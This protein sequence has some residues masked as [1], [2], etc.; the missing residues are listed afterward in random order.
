MHGEL[1]DFLFLSRDKSAN[2]FFF[3]FFYAHNEM[4][5]GMTRET[6]K[7]AG[8]WRRR[9]KRGRNASKREEEEEESER[10]C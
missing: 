4:K 8:L 2:F 9:K 6:I 3:F 5:R 1:I 7:P 10:S